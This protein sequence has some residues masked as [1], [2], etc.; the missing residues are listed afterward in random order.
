MVQERGEP[1]LLPLPCGAVRAPA[2][3]TH[4]PG[5]VPGACFAGPRSPWSLSLAPPAPRRIAPL[6]SSASQLLR[7]SQTSRACASSATAPRLSDADLWCPPAG[8]SRDLP[9]PVQ[10]ASTHARFF[11]HAGL[12]STRV[13]APVRVAFRDYEH[14]GTREFQ[15]F[16]A[17]WL[18]YALPCRRFADTL[19]EANARLG[20]DVDRYSFIAV[21][22]HHLLFAG[23]DR[24]TKILEFRT[25]RSAMGGERTSGRKGKPYH[26]LEVIVVEHG[27]LVSRRSRHGML[28][29]DMQN[30]ATLF[31]WGAIYEFCLSG[32]RRKTVTPS[33]DR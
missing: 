27:Q 17:Q 29:L 18:A 8:Q 33:E 5:P 3:V 15:V 7:Q 11:D 6:C 31:Q 13:D 14:V 19:A 26:F 12:D 28:K 23:L 24:R 30:D 9:V 25:A 20:A 10:R 21:D 1:L 4:F 32:L 22:L 16:A 2:P